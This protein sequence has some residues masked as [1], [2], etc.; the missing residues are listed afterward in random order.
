M[1]GEDIEIVPP[2]EIESIERDFWYDTFKGES[3]QSCYSVIYKCSRGLKYV[4]RTWARDELEAYT[5]IMDGKP[6]PFPPSN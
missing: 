5:Q 3:G 4:V 2:A 6:N 1:D